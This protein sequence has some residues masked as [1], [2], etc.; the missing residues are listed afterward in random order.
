[1]AFV[2]KADVLMVTIQTAISSLFFRLVVKLYHVSCSVKIFIAFAPFS[3]LRYLILLEIKFLPSTAPYNVKALTKIQ[4]QIYSNQIH[5][6]EWL[7]ASSRH[8]VP[9]EL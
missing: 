4:I 6:M 1:M 9:A 2:Q 8:M 3:V 7:F 5:S